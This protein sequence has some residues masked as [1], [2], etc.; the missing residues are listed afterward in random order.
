[1]QELHIVVWFIRNWQLSLCF[2]V[3]TVWEKIHFKN[4]AHHF[5]TGFF[6]IFFT[7]QFIIEN[8]NINISIIELIQHEF[9]LKDRPKWLFLSQHDLSDI[10]SNF[11]HKMSVVSVPSI[12]RYCQECDT[13]NKNLMSRWL[14]FSF[15][16]TGVRSAFWICD[17]SVYTAVT[18]RCSSAYSTRPVYLFV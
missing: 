10:Q 11:C 5:P 17:F 9:A 14:R 15:W 18:Y 3:T 16:M 12:S 4:V 1:M 8:I 7:F 2:S 6:N 13:R